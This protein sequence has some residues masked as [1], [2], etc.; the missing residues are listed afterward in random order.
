MLVSFFWRCDQRGE[1][2][3]MGSSSSGN[4]V[5]ELEVGLEGGGS[6]LKRF[7]EIMATRGPKTFSCTGFLEDFNMETSLVS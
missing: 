6:G 1:N 4:S 7:A 2:I 3:E 5:M